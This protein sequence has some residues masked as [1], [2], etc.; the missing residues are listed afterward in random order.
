M[1]SLARMWYV[2]MVRCGDHSLYTGVSTDPQRRLQQHHAG[3]GSRY[4]VRK[5]AASLV[6]LE[7]CHNLSNA[8]RRELEIKSWTRKEKLALVRRHAMS[9]GR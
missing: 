2:Y 5:G 8:L 7:A 4:V 1:S 3:R 6:Y 9:N